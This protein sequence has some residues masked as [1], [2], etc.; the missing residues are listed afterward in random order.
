MSLSKISVRT[1]ARLNILFK[2]IDMDSQKQYVAHFSQIDS[3]ATKI[4]KM[5]KDSEREYAH[6]EINRYQA[7]K[8]RQQAL[9]KIEKERMHKINGLIE[10]RNH[11]IEDVKRKHQSE[12]KTFIKNAL[13][14]QLRTKREHLKQEKQ[15][16]RLVLNTCRK[17]SKCL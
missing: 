1:R 7:N 13:D 9:N 6:N 3:I 14:I 15:K 4:E 12:N 10:Q 8:S 5:K 16:Q 17:S 2:Q 11:K